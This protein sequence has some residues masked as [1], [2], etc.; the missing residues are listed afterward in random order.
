MDILYFWD[1]HLWTLE[2]VGYPR[3]QSLQSFFYLLLMFTMY[4]EQVLHTTSRHHR[5][6][7]HAIGLLANCTDK[8]LNSQYRVP[9][10]CAASKSTSVFS[11]FFYSITSQLWAHAGGKCRNIVACQLWELMQGHT[12][13]G[14]ACISCADRRR[15]DRSASS[16]FDDVIWKAPAQ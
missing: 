14:V 11:V 15:P 3:S 9:L 2:L 13:K 6:C 10:Y 5:S 16:S 7:C 1:N 8:R 12:L 4:Y